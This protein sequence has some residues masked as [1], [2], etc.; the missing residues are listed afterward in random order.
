MPRW[1]RRVAARLIWTVANLLAMTV[2][3]RLMDH[4][5]LFSPGSRQPVLFIVWHNRLALT[6]PIHRLHVCGRTGGRRQ[7]AALV[8]ASRDGGMLAHVLELFGVIPIRGS[9]SRRGG[10]ALREF[11]AAARAGHDVALTPDGPRGPVYQLQPGV[12]AAAQLTGLPI[13]PVGYDLSWKKTLRTWDRFQIPLPFSRCDLR[14]GAP[15][16]VPP[17]ADAETRERLRQELEAILR[18]L[19]RD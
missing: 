15:F 2:R 7:L 6:I 11:V 1:H 16:R 12:I 8:S 14:F 5:G 19:G 4:S 9:T 18:G 17:D 13:V 3:W 10:P